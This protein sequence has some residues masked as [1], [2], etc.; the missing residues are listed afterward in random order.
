MLR[1]RT[2]EGIDAAAVRRDFGEEHLDYCLASALRHIESGL[3]ETAGSCIRLSRRGLFL[4]DMVMSDLM[5]I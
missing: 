4:S 2:C 1:L 5:R 3:L